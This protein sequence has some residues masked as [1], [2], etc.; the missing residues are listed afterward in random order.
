MAERCPEIEDL[1]FCL[2]RTPGHFSESSA[3]QINAKELLL[4]P[5]TTHH[6]VKQTE[7]SLH[8]E[9]VFDL[10]SIET[11]TTNTNER[12]HPVHLKQVDMESIR[13]IRTNNLHIT[14]L[15]TTPEEKHKW[16]N[17]ALIAL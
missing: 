17:T 3:T 15:H 9:F 11:A 5:D 13:Q 14:H 16:T 7:E 4:I 12:R 2:Q 6:Y 1:Y 10:P 8:E